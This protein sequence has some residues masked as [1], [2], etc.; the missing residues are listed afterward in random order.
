M[1][2]IRASPSDEVDVPLDWIH[3]ELQGNKRPDLNDAK[4][5]EEYYRSGQRVGESLTI[6]VKSESCVN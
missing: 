3:Q 1:N 4:A 5:E 6:Q 2:P